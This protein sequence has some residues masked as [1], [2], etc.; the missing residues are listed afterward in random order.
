MLKDK[1][2][3]NIIGVFDDEDVLINAIKNIK[4]SNFKIKNVFTPYPIDEV[5]HELGLKTRLPYIA[6]F[7]GVSG[8]IMVFAF[9]YWTSVIN[10]PISVGGKPPLS[11]AFIV[12]L[13]VMTIFSGVLL[14]LLTFF[15]IQRLYPGKQ[16]VIVHEGIMDDKYVIVIE[17]TKHNQQSVEEIKNLLISNG[18]IET[19]MKNNIESI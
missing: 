16:A 8:T 13:F 2:N 10:F 15:I 14:S 12:V 3:E 4:K 9:L 7:Y 6:F 18:A 1:N 19:R 5:F 17:T 11:M